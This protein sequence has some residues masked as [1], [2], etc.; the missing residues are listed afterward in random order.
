MPHFNKMSKIDKHNIPGIER[1]F[2]PGIVE[3][4]AADP[5]GFTHTGIASRVG[6]EYV[7]FET[8]ERVYTEEIMSGAFDAVLKNDVRI[9]KNHDSNFILGRTQ[10]Q[11]GKVW[12]DPEGNLRYAW[13]ND[14]E[15]SYAADI[16]RSIQRGD[17]NQSSFG[18]AIDPKNNKWEETTLPDGRTKIKRTMLKFNELFDTSPVTFP[19]SPTTTV[20]QRDFETAYEEYR[21]QQHPP[22]DIFD[23]LEILKRQTALNERLAGL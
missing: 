13:K 11:T 6:T 21:K 4:R 16:A 9:L 8:K 23:E 1:R 19:A 20:S 22:E 2:H 18:F 5:E 7:M 12:V 10:S 15:I 3:E 17:I 14:P